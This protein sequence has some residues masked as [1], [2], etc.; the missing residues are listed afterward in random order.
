M[1]LLGRICAV[2]TMLEQQNGQLLH[3][4]EGFGSAD[5]DSRTRVC[6]ACGSA[7]QVKTI[8][9]SARAMILRTCVCVNPA[10]GKQCACLHAA[11]LRESADPTSA[12]RLDQSL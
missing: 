5:P 11:S 8:T 6:S 10:C 4:C 7:M 1:W 12:K 2:A 9:A 3:P